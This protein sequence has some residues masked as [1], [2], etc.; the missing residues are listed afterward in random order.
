MKADRSGAESLEQ[1]D[2]LCGLV[3]CLA[4]GNFCVSAF[5][6]LFKIKEEKHLNSFVAKNS[7]MHTTRLHADFDFGD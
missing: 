5:M 2:E 3:V 4:S 1:A 7:N 6:Q